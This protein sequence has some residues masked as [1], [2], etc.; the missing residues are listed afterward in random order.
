MKWRA[1][2]MHEKAAELTELV[3]RLRRDFPPGAFDMV[4]HWE[5]LT[6]TD[7]ARPDNHRVLVYI[8]VMYDRASD[9]LPGLGRY[10]FECETPDDEEELGYRVAATG[11]R[12]TY[13]Q[14]RRAV[15]RHLG[16]SAGGSA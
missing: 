9:P 13:E 11:D 2:T 6:A 16:V 5:D 7:L 12:V 3:D 1:V 15:A 8:A 4:N 14:L 10:F